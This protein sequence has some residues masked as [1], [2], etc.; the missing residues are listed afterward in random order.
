MKIKKISFEYEYKKLGDLKVG[1]EVLGPD[2]EKFPILEIHKNGVKD[3]YRITLDDGRYFDTSETHLSTVHFRNSHVRPGKKVYDTVSTKYIKD[4]LEKYIFEIPT[5]ETFSWKELDYPQFIEMLPLHEYEPI[6]EEFIIPDTLKDPKKVYIKKVEKLEKQEECWCLALGYPWGLY[7]TE[8]GII[9]HNSLLTNL[10]MSYI[11]TLFG[12]MREPHKMLGHSAMT[13]YCVSLCSA[14]LNK[15]WDLLGVPFE[16][17]I[18]QSPFFEKVGRHDDIVNI[19]KEDQECKKCYYTTA[20]RGSAKMVFRNNLQLKMMSTEGALLGNTI[21]Y[22]AMTELAWWEQMGWTRED[23]FRFFSKAKQRVDS[24]MNGHYLGRYVIDS[25]PFSMESPIDKWIWETAI[26]DPA[27]YCVLGAKWDYFKKEFPEFF[28]KDGNEIHNWDVAFQ[29][30]KGGKSEPPKGCFTPEEAQAYDPL[31]MIWCPRKDIKNGTVLL[32]SDLAKQNPV[33]FLRDWAGI[34]AGSSDRIFQSGKV[35]ED[36]FD[37]DLKNLYTSLV[38]DAA[39]EP[40]HLIWNQIKDK[41]FINFNGKYLFY[42]EPNAKR[43]LAIDQ[44]TTGD[45]TGISCCHWEYIRDPQTMDIKNVCVVDFSLCII[46]KGGRIN[47]EA[48]RSL[49]EDL[50]N[51]G[52]LNIGLVNFDTFQS[53]S[54]KQTLIRKGITVDYVSVDKNNEPYTILIDYIMH[55][56]F[57]AGK[58]IFLRNNLHSIHWTK[59]DSGTMKCDH[60]KGKIINESNDTNWETSQLGTNAKDLADTCAACIFFLTKFNVEYAPTSEWRSHTNS[61]REVSRERLNKMGFTF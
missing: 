27:W 21:V 6:D 34:P 33:E 16:Q 43:I 35:L 49:V 18:E 59:R 25:S 52:G 38:A 20:A 56:R 8:K 39:E 51:I 4:H 5:D 12:L 37:N 46:P 13:S 44:S 47:L 19:N 11:I 28:D 9:T 36:I 14:T 40:E 22:T 31:D 32:M 45:A 3:I 42:R 53:E 58:N 23:I 17:F 57:F 26:N 29:C 50:I 1:D 54:T 48:I 10:C 61:S 24:R 41:F 7:V 15:A 60:F 2:G 55:N 30:Y